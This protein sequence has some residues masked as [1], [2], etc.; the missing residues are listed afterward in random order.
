[1]LQKCENVSDIKDCGLCKH[2]VHRWEQDKIEYPHGYDLMDME[3]VNC[4]L[5]NRKDIVPNAYEPICE[6]YEE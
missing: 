6:N 1:M 4:Q 5:M 3:L 2:G